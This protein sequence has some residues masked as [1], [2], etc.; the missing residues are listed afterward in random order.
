[1]FS[2]HIC[3]AKCSGGVTLTLAEQISSSVKENFPSMFFLTE[4][5]LSRSGSSTTSHAAPSLGYSPLKDRIFIH[6]CYLRQSVGLKG[7]SVVG[8]GP[9]SSKNSDTYAFSNVYSYTISGVKR[10]F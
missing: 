1:M 6:S 7:I 9:S 4:C 8:F 10:C 3:G 2:V 5:N